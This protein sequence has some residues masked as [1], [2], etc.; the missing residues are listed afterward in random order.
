MRRDDQGLGLGLGCFSPATYPTAA[1]VSPTASK[2]AT[3]NDESVTPTSPARSPHGTPPTRA[4]R[5]GVQN[6]AEVSAADNLR[7]AFETLPMSRVA[8]GRMR[9]T[10]R[11]RVAV[12]IA[13]AAGITGGSAALALVPHAVSASAAAAKTSTTA[14]R[15]SVTT[16]AVAAST[17][18]TVR[19]TTVPKAAT[20]ATSG[21]TTPATTAT[22][23]ASTT[24]STTGTVAPVTQSGGS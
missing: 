8:K 18:S 2:M 6:L 24:G 20:T 17:T 13:G 12:T 4:A 10:W 15:T 3:M 23:S 11:S 1:D 9:R 16:N 5:A 22:T 19:V 21:T 14:A 7:E